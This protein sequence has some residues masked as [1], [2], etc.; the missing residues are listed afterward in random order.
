MPDRLFPR[1][2]KRLLLL[3]ALGLALTGMGQ[4]P[5]F[6]RYYIADLPGLSWLGDYEITAALHLALAAVL[7][8]LLAAFAATWI[9][10][11]AGRPHLTSAGRQRAVI[12][13]ALALTG[14][15]RVLQNGSAPLVGP[16]LVRY[17]DWTHLGLAMALLV[18]AVWKGRKPAVAVVNKG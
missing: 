5:I 14:I 2:Q 7:L 3:A 8:F 9:T 10:A 16:M 4:M 18:F 12:Y 17:L 11:G 15:V 6:S 13:G 1:W